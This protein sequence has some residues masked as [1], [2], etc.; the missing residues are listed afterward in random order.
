MQHP[1]PIPSQR[2]QPR[3]KAS[4][5]QKSALLEGP[6]FREALP[7][8]R[9]LLL[10]QSGRILERATSTAFARWGDRWPHR[11]V[12]DMRT[13]E[14]QGYF[15]ELA[16]KGFSSREIEAEKS[17]L[18]SFYRW[19]LRSGSIATDPTASFHRTRVPLSPPTITWTSGEQR[20][21]LEAARRSPAAY[22]HPL[23]LIALRT[24]LRFGHVLYLEWRHVD[25]RT[26]RI[27][28]PASEVKHG[29][30]LAVPLD[31]DV[32]CELEALAI[33]A[34]GASPVIAPRV[35][36]AAGLPLWQGRPDVQAVLCAFRAVRKLSGIPEG[37]FNSLRLTFAR[38]CASAG[39]PKEYPALVSDWD[40]KSLLEKVYAEVGGLRIL[41]G[42]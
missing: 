33:K 34:R 20:R 37:D 22:L 11:S 21:L 19:A 9:S 29:Q 35:L 32:F 17:L 25:F 13:E 27:T 38:N 41:P 12:G 15:A 10:T 42:A 31:S 36:A 26:R 8:Y 24:G 2:V 28:I 30:E 23:I 4:A 7:E 14:L 5:S 3:D 18:R 1:T 16:Q 40:D 6:Q 39:V